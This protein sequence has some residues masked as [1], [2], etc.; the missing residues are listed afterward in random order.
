MHLI[1]YGDCL[2]VSHN[3]RFFSMNFRNQP[4]VGY[5]LGTKFICKKKKIQKYLHM[6]GSIIYKICGKNNSISV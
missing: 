4:S 5:L 3:V 6:Y 1:K 2:M